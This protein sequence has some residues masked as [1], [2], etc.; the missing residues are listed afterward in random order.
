MASLI[1]ENSYLIPEERKQNYADAGIFLLSVTDLEELS[2]SEE[3]NQVL[4][5]VNA[6]KKQLE[7]KLADHK[8][9]VEEINKKVDEIK[10]D[11]ETKFGELKTIIIESGPSV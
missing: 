1:A 5:E 3:A 2:Q 11:Q 8:K 10:K 7:T 6:L 9:S 4:D